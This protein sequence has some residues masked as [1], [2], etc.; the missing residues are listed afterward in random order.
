MLY[1]IENKYYIRVA[2]MKYT[3]VKLLLRN[4][5]VVIEVTGNRIISNSDTIIKEINFQ[6]EKEKIKASL[7]EEKKQTKETSNTSVRG[8]KYRKRA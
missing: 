1:Q 6:G 3:E 5:D 4:N 8:S 2:P 7:L